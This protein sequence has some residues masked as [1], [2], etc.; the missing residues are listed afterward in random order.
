MKAMGFTTDTY[1]SKLK[2][3]DSV[4]DVIHKI[5]QERQMLPFEIDGVVVKVNSIAHQQ[6]LGRTA[7][8]PKWAMAY[9]FRAQQLQTKIVDIK[10][11]VGRTGK[12][13]PVALVEPVSLSGSVFLFFP[14]FF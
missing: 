14:T 9:K 6:L 5:G 12:V 7:H 3:I 4:L 10:L 2:T 8:S 11:Q 1:A 13:T